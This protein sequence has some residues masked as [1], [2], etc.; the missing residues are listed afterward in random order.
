MKRVVSV[1]L[2][3]LSLIIGFQQAIIVMHFNLNQ[4]AMEQK[5]CVN[6]NEPGLQC[7]GTCFLRKQLQ[8]TGNSESTTISIYQKVDMLP[9]LITKFEANDG[10]IEIPMK[11]PTYNEIQ[12]KAPA[13]EVFVPP[14]IA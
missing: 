10:V 9:A 7:H 5:F 1:L 11:A 3:V 4:A 2:M 14:P 12:Y 13:L 6:K 8:K